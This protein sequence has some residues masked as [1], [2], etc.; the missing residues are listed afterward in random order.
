M[1]NLDIKVKTALILIVTLLIGLVF[2]AMLYRAI[3]Q[4]RVK[5]FMDM[6]TPD[7][8]ARRF[9]RVLDITPGQ[10]EKVKSILDKYA[11]QFFKINQSHMEKVSALFVSIERELS[12][13]L[14]PE[15]MQRIR[16]RR[17]LRPRRFPGRP[18]GSPEWHRPPPDSEKGPPPRRFLDQPRPRENQP[19][20]E[21]KGGQS[22][23]STPFQGKN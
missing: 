12:R 15:Q 20:P 2:G 6:Q 19:P 13:V 18:P 3:F 10:R 22:G 17:F 16:S 5:E 8:F 23:T 1:K 7:G 4:N 21:K 14:T 11:E 9:E